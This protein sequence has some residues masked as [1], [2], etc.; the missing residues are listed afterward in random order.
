MSAADAP[1]I[2]PKPHRNNFNFLRLVF[3]FLVI[4]CHSPELLDGNRNRDILTRLFH[5]MGFG[6]FAVDCFFV[7]SGY[8]IV[9]SWQSRP[10]ASEYLKKRILRIVPGFAAAYFV[11]VFFVGP[12]LADAPSVFFS[13]LALRPALLH[14][15]TLNA[16]PALPGSA[17]GPFSLYVNGSMWTI[18]YEFLCY[19]G[20]MTL[21]VAGVLRV[22]GAFAALYFLSTVFYFYVHHRQ[23]WP[24]PALFGTPFE[25]GRLL[26]FFLAG[27]CFYAYRDRIAYRPQYAAIALLITLAAFKVTQLL[28]FPFPLVLAYLIFFAGFYPAPRLAKIG[29]KTDL[30]YGLYLY[31]WPVQILLIRYFPGMNP[32]L[33]CAVTLPVAGVLAFLSWTLIEKP[34]LALKPRSYPAGS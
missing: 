27:A 4:L 31:A 14:L 5:A 17:Q 29:T 22:R 2:S 24:P 16:P 32:W 6:E 9:Q 10:V 11:S 3:A 21:G 20:V 1:A 7:L 33:L 30:S 23:P 13:R 19:L 28:M 12:A 26:T 15:V 18:Q 34:A 25:W 8:L